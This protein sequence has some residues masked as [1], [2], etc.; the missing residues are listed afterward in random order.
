MAQMTKQFPSGRWS[1][2]RE[3]SFDHAWTDGNKVAFVMH[4]KDGTEFPMQ[5]VLSKKEYEHLIETVSR[6]KTMAKA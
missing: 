4:S 6:A 5:I 1:K 2:P 3:V